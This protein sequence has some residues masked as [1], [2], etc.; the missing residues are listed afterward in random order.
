[1]PTQKK[2]TEKIETVREQIAT[3]K[4]RRND[5][6]YAL[7]PQADGLAR[8]R[9]TIESLAESGRQHVATRALSACSAA[10]LAPDSLLGNP[11]TIGG[12]VRLATPS[13]VLAFLLRDQL[14]AVGEEII[15][16]HYAADPGETIPAGPARR[17]ALEELDEETYLLEVA[18]EA[19]IEEA[20]AAGLAVLRRPDASPEAV[21][22]LERG[23]TVPWDFTSGKLERLL[24]DAEAARAMIDAARDSLMAAREAVVRVDRGEEMDEAA[25]RRLAAAKKIVNQRTKTLE[26]VRAAAVAKIQIGA[27]VEEYITRHR[28]AEPCTSWIARRREQ[29][30]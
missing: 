24:L 18:E 1:M 30:D 27:A 7:V 12:R 2:I 8:W 28:R 11:E 5:A 25:E 10:D 20:E 26:E 4:Q 21:L 3:A 29:H 15:G 16:R 22:G 14:L 17:K 9:S 23:A 19:L 6:E 13:A